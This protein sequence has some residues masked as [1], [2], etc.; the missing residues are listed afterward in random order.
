M[1]ALHNRRLTAKDIWPDNLWTDIEWNAKWAEIEAE[2]LAEGFKHPESY[3]E[4]SKRVAAYQREK[5][6]RV[7]E[8]PGW[9]GLRAS[10]HILR[11]I[12]PE[13]PPAAKVPFTNEEL[14]YIVDKLHGVND[15]FGQDLRE[16]VERMIQPVVASA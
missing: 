4:T 11:Q 12:Y 7:P 15:P 10:Q 1:V 14:Q 2:V 13:K 9:S 3:F 5:R 16:K 6:P 8:H